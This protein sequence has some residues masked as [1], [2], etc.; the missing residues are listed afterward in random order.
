[1]KSIKRIICCCAA[2]MITVL[3]ALTSGD[4]S[5]CY[6][7]TTDNAEKQVI[8]AAPSSEGE[9]EKA[10]TQVT[11]PTAVPIPTQAPQIVWPEPT[12][13]Q[14]T[15]AYVQL[16]ICCMF[17]LGVS[18][19]FIIYGKPVERPADK[20][21]RAKKQKEKAEKKKAREEKKK[22]KSMEYKK[23]ELEKRLVNFKENNHVVSLP[24]EESKD[25]GESDDGDA[26]P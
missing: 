18:I 1:M 11:E 10:E 7:E 12:Q 14:K 19:F 21:K 16:V 8:A 26:R 23:K 15:S 9:N 4:A 13:K 3:I 25:N 20:Y 22:Q 24:K 5:A 6:A 2:A 17:G